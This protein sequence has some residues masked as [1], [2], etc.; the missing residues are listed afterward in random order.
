MAFQISS[1]VKAI[2]PLIAASSGLVGLLGERIAQ[3]RNLAADERVK[4]LEQDMIKMGEVLAATVGQLQATAQA[5]RE[6]AELAAFRRWRIRL[7]CVFSVLALALSVLA[8]VLA[9]R[10]S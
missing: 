8:V 10:A 9:L 5:L 1:I 4:K 6:Q 2:T 3:G 7:A